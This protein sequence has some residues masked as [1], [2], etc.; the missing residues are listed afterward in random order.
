MIK[1]LKQMRKRACRC[2]NFHRGYTLPQ[3]IRCDPSGTMIYARGTSNEDYESKGNKVLSWCVLRLQRYLLVRHCQG[4]GAFSIHHQAKEIALLSGDRT[5][6]VSIAR[7]IDPAIR[8]SRSVIM[9][10]LP[11]MT[12]LVLNINNVILLVGQLSRLLRL[13]SSTALENAGGSL[14]GIFASRH[15]QMDSWSSATGS[16]ACRRLW[17]CWRACSTPISFGFR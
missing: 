15:R 6:V 17:S 9:H 2:N 10:S 7:G 13:N 3:S 11:S 4:S 1:C 14:N 12:F 5:P 16:R 8:Q